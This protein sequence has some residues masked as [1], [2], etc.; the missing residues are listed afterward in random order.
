M[1][2][3]TNMKTSVQQRSEC[4][5]FKL[6]R[7]KGYMTLSTTSEGRFSVHGGFKGFIITFKPDIQKRQWVVYFDFRG[8]LYVDM[9]WVDII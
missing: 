9:F 4:I 7:L 6:N 1:P 2:V 5:N 3:W 8:K